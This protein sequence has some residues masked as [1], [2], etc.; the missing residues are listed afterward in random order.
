MGTESNLLAYVWIQGICSGEK[1]RP[2]LMMLRVWWWG[3]MVAYCPGEAGVGGWT[4]THSVTRPSVQVIYF[5]YNIA[6]PKT[7]IAQNNNTKNRFPALKLMSMYLQRSQPF[8]S[9]GLRGGVSPF[10]LGWA[11]LPASP[12]P[13]HSCTSKQ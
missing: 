4:H 10:L 8:G 7:T 5:N 3:V 6:T 12:S 2:V 11:L 1:V 13:R 9:L